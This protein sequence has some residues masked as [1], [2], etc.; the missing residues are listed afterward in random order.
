MYQNTRLMHSKQHSLANIPTENG[1]NFGVKVWLNLRKFSWKR[2]MEKLIKWP[3]RSSCTNTCPLPCGLLHK[4]PEKVLESL[5]L[6]IQL[7]TNLEN[8]F[9]QL[10]HIISQG[11]SKKDTTCDL[12][13]FLRIS[14]TWIKTS[15][16]VIWTDKRKGEKVR[17]INYKTQTLLPIYTL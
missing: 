10:N 6:Q 2:K 8:T 5:I 4:C 7:Q 16:C 9:I 3:W 17:I 11:N 1:R 14:S 13:L 15:G 12:R